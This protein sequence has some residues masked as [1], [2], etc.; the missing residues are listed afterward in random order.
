MIKNKPTSVITILNVQ[1]L[2]LKSK[3]SDQQLAGNKDFLT[4]KSLFA[5]TSMIPT[6]ITM[7]INIKI[8]FIPKVNLQLGTITIIIAYFF[9][10]NLI[11]GH[12]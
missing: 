2:K 10:N 11:H 6:V 4:T 3:F 12:R 5:F 7:L 9:F 1:K 8:K